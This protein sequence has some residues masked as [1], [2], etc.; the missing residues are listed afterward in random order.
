MGKAAALS[1]N[2][3]RAAMKWSFLHWGFSAWWCCAIVGLAL[4]FFS[5][6]RGLPLTIRF[7]LTPLFGRTF[8]HPLG[9]IFAIVSV[10]ATI[11]GVSVSVSVS[12]SVTVG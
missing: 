2:N 4:S 9:H 5:Y 11:L 6:W 10:I 8:E 7:D 3:V 12:V 1:A